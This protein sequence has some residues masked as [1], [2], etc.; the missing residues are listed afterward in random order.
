MGGGLTDL[1]LNERA[2]RM[3]DA[4][5]PLADRLRVATRTLPG[6]ARVIDAGIAAP[7]GFGTDL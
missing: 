1:G 2:W 6:G 7:G 4:M 5:M 3:A